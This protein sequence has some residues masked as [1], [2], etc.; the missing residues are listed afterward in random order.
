MNLLPCHSRSHS[1]FDTSY[2]YGLAHHFTKITI[3]SPSDSPRFNSRVRI[4]IDRLIIGSSEQRKQLI[5][6]T[7]TYNLN[8]NL[9][10]VIGRTIR[11][12]RGAD[13]GLSW[14]TEK[15]CQ[16]REE[17]SYLP[18]TFAPSSRSRDGPPETAPAGK[19]VRVSDFL[20]SFV[21]RFSIGSTRGRREGWRIR[22]W[23]RCVVP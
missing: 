21:S 9:R 15:F 5:I 23:L 17:P 16:G 1:N 2:G 11:E 12:T 14:G 18:R 13:Q 7:T 6:S 22:S 19:G 20:S 10:S 3:T 4:T 8:H